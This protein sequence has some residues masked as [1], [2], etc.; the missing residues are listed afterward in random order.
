MGTADYAAEIFTGTSAECAHT[1]SLYVRE[2]YPA[3]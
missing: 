2:A 3:G 1:V